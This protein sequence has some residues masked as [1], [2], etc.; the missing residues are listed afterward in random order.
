MSSIYQEGYNAAPPILWAAIVGDLHALR[1]AIADG[2]D[3]DIY[4]LN[5]MISSG[6]NE[7]AVIQLF[8]GSSAMTHSTVTM[9]TTGGTPA[10][11]IRAGSNASPHLWRQE[12]T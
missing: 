9:T 1:R 8:I 6:M 2:A 3:L 5:I 4:V 7:A 10:F 12:P 11:L